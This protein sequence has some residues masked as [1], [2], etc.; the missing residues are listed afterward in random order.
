MSLSNKA[1]AK[2]LSTVIGIGL[3]H[4]LNHPERRMSPT[5]AN[6]MRNVS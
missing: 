4:S 3:K 2:A 1:D 5:L 6:L